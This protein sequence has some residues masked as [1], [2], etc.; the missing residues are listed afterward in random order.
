[1]VGLAF[2]AAVLSP[3]KI[4][5]IAIKN[6]A[7]S[8]SP[9][10]ISPP[11]AKIF[12]I[13]ITI[14]IVLSPSGEPLCSGNSAK[15]WWDCW[16][17]DSG[18][19]CLVIEFVLMRRL[20]YM[21]L[22]LLCVLFVA[23][24]CAPPPNGG[25]MTSDGSVFRI[26]DVAGGSVSVAEA[27]NSAYMLSAVPAADY[28]FV[29]WD[30]VGVLTC[31]DINRFNAV[32]RVTVRDD[33]TLTP[34]Y[35]PIPLVRLFIQQGENGSISLDTECGADCGA[36]AG[37]Q[38]LLTAMPD[39]GY[40]FGGWRCV[41]AETHPPANCPAEV[42]SESRPNLTFT[43]TADLTITADFTAE[44]AISITA[45]DAFLPTTATRSVEAAAICNAEQDCIYLIGGTSTELSLGEP[46]GMP[47]GAYIWQ[48]V[49]DAPHLSLRSD[50]SAT[51]TVDVAADI[52]EILVGTVAV[53]A[54]FGSA[55][56]S[57][58]DTVTLVAVPPALAVRV[59]S[60]SGTVIERDG[61]YF[62]L[63]AGSCLAG[64]R[65]LENGPVPT[66]HEV[67]I[68]TADEDVYVMGQLV[69]LDEVSDVG[70]LSIPNPN[71]AWSPR[72]STV[73]PVGDGEAVRA[74]GRL[75]EVGTN[76]GLADVL[77]TQSQIG[78]VLDTCERYFPE[79]LDFAIGAFT[80]C[81][82]NTIKISPALSSDGG[83]GA[84]ILN[85]QNEIV[86]VVSV[87]FG[88]SVEDSFT[89]G[90]LIGGTT[91]LENLFAGEMRCLVTEAGSSEFGDDIEE[92]LV[93]SDCG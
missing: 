48:V 40:Q 84:A 68:P 51:V 66:E 21:A 15:K 38:A 17:A 77:V 88:A 42:A 25:V 36:G 71:L 8:I 92:T 80:G 81:D 23:F 83:E 5:T 52:E 1:M 34:I 2:W 82:S 46:A 90:P 49:G 75:R 89:E 62:V 11:T 79:V 14:I 69:G 19:C 39:E 45:D 18:R 50:A 78:A 44:P 35:E 7:I 57:L 91:I 20:I 22:V 86:S 54:V 3:A 58:R 85:S 47:I 10:V 30:C 63:T 55:L 61:D 9:P 27:P 12:E 24:G 56:G 53:E 93:V 65:E 76:A 60:C 72:V 28:R 13:T 73:S 41:N 87:G 6:T 33:T 16:Y 37:W 4:G 74:A 70:L 29:R 31:A 67:A 59:R 32:A 64:A 43:P 26:R